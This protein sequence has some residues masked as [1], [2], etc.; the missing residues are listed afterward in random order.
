MFDDLGQYT[1]LNSLG[2]RFFNPNIYYN[3]KNNVYTKRN[4]NI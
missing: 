1:I 4:K 2:I 3:F